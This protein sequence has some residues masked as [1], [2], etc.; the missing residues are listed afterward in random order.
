MNTLRSHPLAR[1]CVLVLHL[2]VMGVANATPW[3]QADD[4]MLGARCS[5][6]RA[7]LAAAGDLDEPRTLDCPLCLPL[8]APPAY[9]A[10]LPATSPV[11][12]AVSAARAV[13]GC[14]RP[15]ALPP[16]RAPPRA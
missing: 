12:E 13:S 4:G 2:L 14:P 15:V 11:D 8:Q 6:T 16:A 7:P 10:S 3:L 5:S 1:L 9:A